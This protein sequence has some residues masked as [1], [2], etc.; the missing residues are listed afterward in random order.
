M[1][2]GKDNHLFVINFVIDAEGKLFGQD[3]ALK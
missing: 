2:N 3:F 1:Q